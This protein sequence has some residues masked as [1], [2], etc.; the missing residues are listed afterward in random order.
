MSTKGKPFDCLTAVAE[1]DKIYDK[2]K[3]VK[4]GAK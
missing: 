3:Q 2:W 1:I 4:I